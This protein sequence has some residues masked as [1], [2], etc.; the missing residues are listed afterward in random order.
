MEE[1]N[2]N[3]NSTIVE[4]VQEQENEKIL[5]NIEDDAVPDSTDNTNKDTTVINENNT[6]KNF[7]NDNDSQLNK[8][9]NIT[10]NKDE[11]KT[12][13]C[14]ISYI[15]KRYIAVDFKGFGIQVNLDG[16]K[17]DE[18]AKK[19]ELEYQ[20]DIGSPQFKFWIKKD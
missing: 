8:N 18:N 12:Q 20:S 15:A 14:P 6:N 4:S 9:S 17:I 11:I 5:E 3:S 19:I 16:I 10:K 13:I 7:L 2:T 1:V